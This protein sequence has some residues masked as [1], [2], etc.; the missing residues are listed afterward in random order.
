MEL[1]AT[2]DII[3]PDD[4]VCSNDHNTVMM[5]AS[6]LGLGRSWTRCYMSGGSLK[7][8][9]CTFVCFCRI[10]VEN[11]KIYYKN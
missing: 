4:I 8:M 3:T 7:V 9:T 1:A 5:V 6:L 10:Y 11:L 2:T